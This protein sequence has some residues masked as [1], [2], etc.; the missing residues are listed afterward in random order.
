MVVRFAE[1]TPTCPSY[2]TVSAG[3]QILDMVPKLTKVVK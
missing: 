3:L 2:V 1:N